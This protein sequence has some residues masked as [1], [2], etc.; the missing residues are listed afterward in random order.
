MGSRYFARVIKADIIQNY[1]IFKNRLGT[2]HYSVSLLGTLGY[3]LRT[4][5]F[6]VN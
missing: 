1:F 2:F 5:T 4:V 3:L 6:I